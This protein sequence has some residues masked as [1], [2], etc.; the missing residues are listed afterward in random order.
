MKFSTLA[1]AALGAA[2]AKMLLFGQ[3]PPT[4]QLV[5]NFDK[6]RF[7]G[8]WYEVLRDSDFMFEM[9]QE[10][11]THQYTNLP[12]GNM[13]LYFRAWSWMTGYM[14]IDGRM[15]ECGDNLDHT[16]MVSM[17]TSDKTSPYDVLWINDDYT[18]GVNY[19]CTEMMMGMMTFQWWSVFSRDQTASADQ[20][21]EAVQTI[22]D[23]DVGFTA[24]NI[25]SRATMQG[26]EC[27]Y[28]WTLAPT[29]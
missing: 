22:I 29:V 19:M 6:E 2:D 16:C 21:R 25:G 14:G 11:V 15:T 18:I 27:E 9:G 26:G 24:D 4:P 12:D 3:C 13:G 10:C 23:A 8:N 20:L 28:D 5:S 17:S 1:L 7:A